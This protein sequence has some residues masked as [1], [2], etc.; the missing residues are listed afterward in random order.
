MEDM[1]WRKTP[2]QIKEFDT[3]H[4]ARAAISLLGR[5][6]KEDD[7]PSQVEYTSVRDYLLTTICIN[8][9]SR[10]GTLANM[11]LGEFEAATD[12]DGCFV[13]EHKT[14]TT[15]GPVNVVFTASLHRYT[16]IFVAK[17]RNSLGDVSTGARSPLFLSTNQS[18][19]HT[20]QVGAQIGACWGKVFGKKASAGGAPSFR[21]AAVSAVH[22]RKEEMRGDLANL[23]VHKPSTADRYYLL[24][25]KSKSAVKTS[26]ELAK[27]MRSGDAPSTKRTG[28]LADEDV[29]LPS[30]H[31]ESSPARYK[32]TPAQV[33]E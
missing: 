7:T 12:E 31:S 17:F 25:N 2:G 22:E 32:W 6:G 8:N 4:V 21:K 28:D 20:S 33:L 10:S 9:G 27:V 30:R 11:T 14:F 18:K 19:M 29:E 5:Y 15:H 26:K 24:Q 13:K 16:K 23:M 3:S 1:S